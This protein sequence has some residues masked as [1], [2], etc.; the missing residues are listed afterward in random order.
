MTGKLTRDALERLVFAR[1]GAANPDVIAGPAFGED[2]AAIRDGDRTLVAS[3]DPVSLAAGRIGRIGV[4]VATNDVAAAGARPEF[5]LVTLLLPD[6]DVDLLDEITADLDAEAERLGVSVVGGHTE[7]VAGLDRPLLSLA[8]FGFADRHVPTG[9]A[10]PGDR[11]LLTKAAGIEATAVLA[12]DFRDEFDLP[13]DACDAAA[14]FF[15]D[16][17]VVREATAL[18]PLA[19]AMHDPTEGG[20]LQG[21]VELATAAGVGIDL[22]R[23][24]IPVREATERLCSIAGVDPLRVL[25]SGALL[26]TV[27]PDDVEAALAALDDAGVDGRVVG[28]IVDGPPGV[29]LDDER[30]VDPIRDDMYELWD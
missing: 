1:T 28:R 29:G 7:A 14:G 6:P 27:G 26:A 3:V 10:A 9:G 21:A 19:T 30:Y 4:A 16:L 2:A 23:G 25:G 22:D 18:A 11:L 24:A 13:A 12:T 20:V 15:D 8:C 5:L 17:S